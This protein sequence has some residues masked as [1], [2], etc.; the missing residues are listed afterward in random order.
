M[1]E[2]KP[3]DASTWKLELGGAI[4]DR[5]SWT[6]S[7]L[8][9]L[10]QVSQITRHVCVEGWDYIGKWS[11]VPLKLFLEHVGADLSAGFVNFRCADGYSSS[12]DMPTRVACANAVDVALCGPGVA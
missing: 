8:N 11:G 4:R 5:K 10:P 7:E 1:D 3:L 2:V 6:L 12:L 9:A